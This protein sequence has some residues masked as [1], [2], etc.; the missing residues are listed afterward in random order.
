[1]PQQNRPNPTQ[2]SKI[3]HGVHQ[4]DFKTEKEAYTL[5]ELIKTR[6][7]NQLVSWGNNET[8]MRFVFNCD[9][10][11]LH[12]AMRQILKKML[13]DDQTDHSCLVVKVALFNY[14]ILFFKVTL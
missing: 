14:F 1:M 4:I 10:E 7:V 5:T 2:F 6:Q 8:M 3:F 11:V 12:Q 9:I 13:L